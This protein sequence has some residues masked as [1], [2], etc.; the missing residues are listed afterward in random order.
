MCANLCG[1]DID[2]AL[3]IRARFCVE[4]E[5]EK[6]IGGRSSISENSRALL[7]ADSHGLMPLNGAEIIWNR[8]GHLGELRN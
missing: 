7:A 8:R 4:P 3:P 5:S 1:D 6:R 2:D